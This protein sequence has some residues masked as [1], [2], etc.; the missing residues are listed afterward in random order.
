MIKMFLEWILSFFQKKE[1]KKI[2][3]EIEE[4]DDKLEKIDD[5]EP[6]DSELLDRLND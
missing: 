5:E 3:K 1:E 2:Y 4:I 6:T